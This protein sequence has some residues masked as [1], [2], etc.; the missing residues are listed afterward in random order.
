MKITQNEK[1]IITLSNDEKIQKL[2]DAYCD[3]V[4]P[5]EDVLLWEWADEFRILPQVSSS[6]HG[7]WRTSRFPY[8]K[9][10]MYELSPQSPTRQVVVMKGSQTGFTE[11]ALNWMFCTIHRYPAPMLYVQ[12]TIDAVEKFS[13]QRFTASLEVMPHVRDII[14]PAVS[15]S[16]ANTIRMKNF[17]GGVIIMGGANSAA[18][19]RSMPIQNLILDE[20][21]SYEHDIQEEGSPSDLAIRRTANFPRRK[22]FRL[23]TP[24]IKETSVIEPLFHS[25]DQRYYYVPCPFC[26]YHQ[27]ISW[28]NIKWD[29]GDA[30]SVR[31]EC[32]NCKQGIEELHKTAMLDAGEWRKKYPGRE[33]ASFHLSALYSPLGFYSWKDA[34]DLFVEAETTLNRGKLKVF[35]NT[36]LGETWSETQ[37]TIESRGLLKRREEYKAE[38][39]QGVVLLV[40]GADVQD[41]RIEMEV[42]GLGKHEESW[43]IEYNVM[44][45]DTERE[46]VWEILDQHLMKT[47][48]HESGIDMKIACAAI[49]SGHR[50]EVV[51]NF[52]KPREFRRIFPIKGQDGWGK[53]YITR[54]KKRLKG[55]WLYHLMVDELK[56]KVY[57]QL[58]IAEPGPGYCH[59]PLKEPFDK[60]YFMGLTA[61]RMTLS[62]GARPQLKWVLPE[63]KRNEPLDC[64]AYAYGARYILGVDLDKLADH[65]PFSGIN[66]RVKKKKVRVHSTGY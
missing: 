44:V 54:P 51:Y 65:G 35:I 22:I 63:G 8:L 49:D 10:P 37:R 16:S 15:R 34:V 33:I 21:D 4:I 40:A 23:S 18:S 12:K 66:K 52:C 1:P 42:L 19:L 39:P 56:S 7:P 31:M 62:K 2:I 27:V 55:I 50:A 13:K 64:R 14:A 36:V 6:E 59:F 58:G 26:G 41:D 29:E 30:S 45:G 5:P 38:V 47:Y 61:E 20:E 11:I 57:S 25:G 43:S 60:G 28:R 32:Q 53:G 24:T 3:G 48:H 46:S 9:E 17:P